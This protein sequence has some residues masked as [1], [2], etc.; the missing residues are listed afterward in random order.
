MHIGRLPALGANRCLDLFAFLVQDVTKH[1]FCAFLGEHFG[2]HSALPASTTANQRH[3]AGK[4][5]H[6]LSPL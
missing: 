6:I 2:F 5:C 4:P 1:H 3:F